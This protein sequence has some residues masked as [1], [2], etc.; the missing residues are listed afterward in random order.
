[1]YSWLGRYDEAIGLHKEALDMAPDST[2]AQINLGFAYLCQNRL[3]EAKVALEGAL[4]SDPDAAE[5]HT[6]IVIIYSRQGRPDEAV[7][8]HKKLAQWLRHATISELP[9][10]NKE[11]VMPRP[12]RPTLQLMPKNW[13]RHVPIFQ[14]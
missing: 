3:D 12:M 10:I 2:D 9:T 5:A 8:A 13:K 11:S 7:I 14:W 6:N 1:V 4:R